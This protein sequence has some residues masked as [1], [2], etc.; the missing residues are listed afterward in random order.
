MVATILRFILSFKRA[1]FLFGRFFLCFLFCWSFFLLLSGGFFYLFGDYLSLFLPFSFP[2]FLLSYLPS[3]RLLVF[4][5]HWKEPPKC[6]SLF[7]RALSSRSLFTFSLPLSLSSL[8][9]FSL[10]PSAGSLSHC[11]PWYVP[12][13]L[14]SQ[15]K[16]TH[17]G[18]CVRHIVFKYIHYL[19]R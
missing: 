9:L 15:Y 10:S 6:F 7:V 16:E 4:P 5:I 12:P 17:C 1:L 19:C 8:S 11:P 2:T 13:C 14:T 18:L 3:Y